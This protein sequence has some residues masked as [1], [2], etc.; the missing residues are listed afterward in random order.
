M[1]TTAAKPLTND[2]K[3]GETNM[4]VREYI[5]ARYVPLFMGEWS[6]ENAYEPLSVVTHEG[7]S[8]TSRQAVPTGIPITNTA[9]WAVTGNF[10]AQVD[11]YRREVL[12]FDRRITANSEDIGEINGNIKTIESNIAELY[13]SHKAV[14]EQRYYYIISSNGND[15]TAKPVFDY[16]DE[17]FA[18]KTL[19]KA[20]SDA[21]LYS[22]E[23]NFRFV[24]SGTFYLHA[25][26]YVGNVIHFY[27]IAPDVKIALIPADDSETVFAYD[28]HMNFGADSAI[29]QVTVTVQTSEANNTL[30]SLQLEGSFAYFNNAEINVKELYTVQGSAYFNNVVLNGHLNTAYCFVRFNGLTINNIEN[31]FAYIAMICNIRCEGANSNCLVIGD[32]AN[33]AGDYPAIRV[34]S[35]SINIV[36]GIRSV[37]NSRLRYPMFF[38]ARFSTVHGALST[39]KNFDDYAQGNS[40]LQSYSE[41]VSSNRMMQHGSIAGSDI[42]ANSIND[43]KITFDRAFPSKPFV[44]VNLNSG[45]T[46]PGIGNITACAINV[47]STGFTLRVFNNDSAQRS[48]AFDWLAVS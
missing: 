15:E 10:N 44:S 1:W 17:S 3:I 42:P 37:N 4:T 41:L 33:I 19:D 13:D 22:N 8:Y 5:G 16:N 26:S 32:N 46:A 7:N 6:N 2:Q 27:S 12:E 30:K 18:Y 29:N 31:T 23:I 9:Y 38:D 11:A 36:D 21:V 45:S 39:F 28:N 14:V 24:S 47:S 34:L 25:T 20:M 48:P 35:S 43:T 40:S